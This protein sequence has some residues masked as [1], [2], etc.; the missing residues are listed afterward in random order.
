LPPEQR[1]KVLGP[2]FSAEKL[3]AQKGNAARGKELVTAICASCHKIENIGVEFGPN[4]SQIAKKYDR[5]KLLEQIREPGKVI[6]PDWFPATVKSSD[7]EAVTGFLIGK[8]LK[9]A[10]GL[11]RD[12][13]EE[14]IKSAQKARATLMPEGL[15]ENLSAE[16]AADLLEFLSARQ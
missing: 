5:A 9:M 8:V 14:E 1:R 2:N 4:L 16:E 12:L 7:G 10:G 6:E 15:L 13:S 3:L 11:S